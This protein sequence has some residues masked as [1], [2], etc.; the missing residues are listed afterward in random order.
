MNILKIWRLLDHEHT[1]Y[2]YL[3]R[4]LISLSNILSFLAYTSYT[5]SSYIVRY[6]PKYFVVLKERG[7]EV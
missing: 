6:T 2:P 1:M 4:S 7:S 5:F 3:F